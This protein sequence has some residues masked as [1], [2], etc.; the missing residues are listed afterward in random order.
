[1]Q[2]TTT[3]GVTLFYD[4]ADE[5]D[6]VA[7]V[8]E[9]GYGAWQWGWQYDALA[10]PYET[11]VLDSRGTGRSDR[12]PGPYSVDRLA[13]DLEAVLADSGAERAHLVGAGLGG[14]VALQYAHSYGRARTLTLA[15]T[16]PSGEDIDEAAFRAL[17]PPSDDPTAL[18]ESLDGA[19][20]GR[21]RS[22]QPDAVDRICEWR[23]DDADSEGFEAQATAA[24]SFESPPLYESTLPTLVVHGLADP[25]VP[26][27]VGRQLA[28][29]LPRGS[30]EAVEGRHLCFVEHA[31]AVT[32]RLAGFLD[33]YR[34]TDR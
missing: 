19:L 5:G 10:G 11:L 20:S 9:A 24:L 27:E 29:D 3:D 33:E 23:K 18:R 26:V 4:T 6:T 30:F 8:G 28:G 1:V 14:M 7:F 34:Q 22:E 17:H 13:A 32:D 21:Y 2:T 25:V 15:G 31:R 16:A 12:P